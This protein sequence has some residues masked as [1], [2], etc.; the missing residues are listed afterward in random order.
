MAVPASSVA[1]LADLTGVAFRHQ[2]F[3]DQL[4][5]A[6]VVQNVF[7]Y[8]A[9]SPFYDHNCSNERLRIKSIHP[10]DTSQ[11]MYDQFLKP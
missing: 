10:L 1:P 3:L 5:G 8:F 9:V 11:L 2:S 6:L 7:E 4:W